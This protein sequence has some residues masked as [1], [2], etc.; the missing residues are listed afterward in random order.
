MSKLFTIAGTSTLNGTNTFR[1]ATGKVNVR[2]AKLKRH[3]H[4]DVDLIQLPGSMSKEDAVAFLVNQ[5]R[6][7]VIPTNRKTG[8]VELSDEQK[9]AAAEAARKAEFTRRMAEARAAKRAARVA[10]QD[11]N[12]LAALT[13]GEQVE[14]P[15]ADTTPAV[16]TAEDE[17]AA[18]AA[19][20]E[21]LAVLG[22]DAEQEANEA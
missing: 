9:A 22:A 5:G 20:D 8:P 15:D 3:G 6:D 2:V 4:T 18:V 1:F 17:A 12:Y 19:A 13:G 10:A 14:V 16:V 7:A 11:E 21:L